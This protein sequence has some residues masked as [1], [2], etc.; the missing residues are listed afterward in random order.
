MKNLLNKILQKIAK[1][2]SKK[3]VATHGVKQRTPLF[4]VVVNQFIEK[5]FA[6]NEFKEGTRIKYEYM[7]ANITLFL[8][9]KQLYNLLACDVKLK[10]MQD[11]KLFLHQQLVSCGKS[12]SARHLQ[13]CKRALKYAVQM[14]YINYNPIEALECKRDKNKPL[15]CIERVELKNFICAKFTNEI[16]TTV[17][18]LYVFQSCTG[19]SYEG[20]YNHTI[21]FF[22]N[23]KGEKVKW[24]LGNRRKN[25]EPYFVPMFE[26]AEFILN[27]Y[28]GALPKITNSAYNRVLKEVG[29]ILGVKKKLTTHTARKTFATLK[30]QMGWST[31][32]I[33]D[34]LGHSSIKTT[35]NYYFKNSKDTVAAELLKHG[36]G[37][38]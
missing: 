4:I 7:I 8:K 21:S 29:L 24:I 32:S 11:L 13:L 36:M 9:T 3:K 28:N 14:E 35:E 1:F 38:V 30:R 27:V 15:I 34:M 12:H 20:L 18:H 17:A 5:Q 26:E 19:L 37:S 31:E 33:A 2:L 22:E 16:Y 23:D 25:A 10:H 6:E